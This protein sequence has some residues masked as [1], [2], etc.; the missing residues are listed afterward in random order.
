MQNENEY[1]NGLELQ[2]SIQLMKNEHKTKLDCEETIQL[3]KS[4]SIDTVLEHVNP[5]NL[6]DM[7]AI[8]DFFRY[9][10]NY[11][12]VNK[13][14]NKVLQINPHFL[15]A[16]HKKGILFI[17][18]VEYDQALT[19]F[20]KVLKMNPEYERAWNNKGLILGRF[21]QF[22]DALK[23][24][25]KALQ[26]NPEFDC[27][28][29]NKGVTLGLLGRKQDAIECFNKAIQI[30]PNSFTAKYNKALALNEITTFIEDGFFNS[31]CFQCG[32]IGSQVMLDNLIQ[33]E[34]SYN[35]KEGYLEII[36]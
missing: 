19:C 5:N 22:Q 17:N 11:E 10:C 4:G 23:C 2:E 25:E 29:S 36:Q 31:T 6:D 33:N 21:E 12:I 16:W 24:F 32:S 3:I 18:M 7:L 8:S 26:I 9:K 1:E 14:I 28:W 13:I 20:D 34:A 35:L 27:A 30:N 15:E